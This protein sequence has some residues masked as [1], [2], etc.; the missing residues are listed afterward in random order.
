MNAC[1]D[2]NV[3]MTASSKYLIFVFYLSQWHL[4]EFEVTGSRY[5]WKIHGTAIIKTERLLEIYVA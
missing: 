4:M 2:E 3:C 1:R 5:R